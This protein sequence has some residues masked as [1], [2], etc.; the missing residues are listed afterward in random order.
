[1]FFDANSQKFF[2]ELMQSVVDVG[3]DQDLGRRVTKHDLG[4]KGFDEKL[5]NT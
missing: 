4:D 1:M 5:S 2:Q 3:E